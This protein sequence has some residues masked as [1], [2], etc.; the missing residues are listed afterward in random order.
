LKEGMHAM[1]GREESNTSKTS[2]LRAP[3]VCPTFVGMIWCT[4]LKEKA[5]LCC[6]YV[7]S[8]QVLERKAISLF[9][10][11]LFLAVD[12][13]KMKFFAE[14]FWPRI[15]VVAKMPKMKICCLCFTPKTGT[16]VLGCMGVLMSILS[17]IPHCN[18][19]EN[20]EF[21]LSEF[22]KNQRIN[23]GRFMYVMMSSYKTICMY[24]ITQRILRYNLHITYVPSP[25]W[26]HAVDSK[27]SLDATAQVGT[28]FKHI[29][30]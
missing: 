1:H 16:V 21:Y 26:C 17:L 20:H 28:C 6:M 27:I 24:L 30:N 11:Q 18:L 23:G 3:F 29:S 15:P 4:A 9:L 14:S 13:N 12:T 19:I 10:G 22:V 7:C 8:A 5:L 2:V 25:E